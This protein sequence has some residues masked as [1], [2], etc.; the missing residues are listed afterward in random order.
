M[1]NE[2]GNEEG[3]SQDLSYSCHLLL[4]THSLL[5]RREEQQ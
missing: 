1:R 5:L 2:K 3:K 4:T